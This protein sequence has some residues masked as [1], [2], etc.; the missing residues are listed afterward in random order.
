MRHKVIKNSF[1][2]RNGP[3]KALVRGL[4]DSLVENGRIK[5]TLTKAK[6]IRSKVEKAITRG[7]DNTVHSRRVLAAQYPFGNTVE[8]IF[9]KISP[10]FM[11]RP[12]GYTRI[13]KLGERAG[14]NAPMAYIEFVDFATAEK[15]AV[16]NVPNVDRAAKLRKNKR[17]MQE[18]SRITNRQIFK[19]SFSILK[20]ALSI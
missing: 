10:R 17:K 19:K 7:K 18:K 4:I 13:V 5:T 3:R 20:K 11:D 12:G 9:G 2:R 8:T 6:V 15:Q 16:V 1:G 14:D